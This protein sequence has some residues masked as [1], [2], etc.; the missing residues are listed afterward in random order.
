[1]EFVLIEPDIGAPTFQIVGL[2]RLVIAGVAMEF[3][4]ADILVVL[5]DAYGVLRVGS[6]YAEEAAQKEQYFGHIERFV[7][8]SKA[9]AGRPD[10]PP[11]QPQL[12]TPAGQSGH[13]AADLHRNRLS[14]RNGEIIVGPVARQHLLPARDDLRV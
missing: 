4:V 3:W 8:R 7:L 5:E 13:R 11:F 1:M 10:I 9:K 6:R 14:R 2:R 12:W